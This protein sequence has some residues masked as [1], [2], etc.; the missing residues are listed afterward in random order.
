VCFSVL[1]RTPGGEQM[2]KL[3][4]TVEEMAELLHLRPSSISRKASE[5]AIPSV[6][7]G[8]KWVFP[9]DVIQEWL[10]RKAL[11]QYRGDLILAEKSD[12]GSMEL[13]GIPTF[14]LGKIYEKEITREAIYGDYLSDR[15]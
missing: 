5:G 12:E 1:R 3:V 10:R 8:R 2:E 14:K 11:E 15:L 4:L 7:I 9:S 13:K 6:K